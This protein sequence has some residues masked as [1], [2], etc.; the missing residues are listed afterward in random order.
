MLN[1][2]KH[3]EAKALASQF[4]AQHPESSVAW[5]AFGTCLL[6]KGELEEAVAAFDRALLLSKEDPEVFN[7]SAL[8]HYLLGKPTEAMRRYNEAIRLEPSYAEAFNNRGNLFARQ[9][10]FEFAFRDF[11]AA[12][13]I[14]ANYRDALF[15]KGVWLKEIGKFGE[16]VSYFDRALEVAPNDKKILWKKATAS[17][18]LGD[19]EAGWPLYELRQFQREG[20][21]F[22]RYDCEVWRGQPILGRT[23]LVSGEQGFGDAIQFVRYC[24]LLSKRG[25]RVLLE[26]Q[27]P[28]VRLF[29][30]LVG[31]D[32]VFALGYCRLAFDLHCMMM[33]LPMA[34]KTIASSIPSSDAYLR[35]EQDLVLH[36]NKRLA[37]LA[38]PRVGIV[39]QGGYRPNEPETL[40]VNEQRNVP[41]SLLAKFLD[42][43]E[44]VFV[45][46]QKGELAEQEI[47]CHG[48]RLWNKSK[49]V[50][51]TDELRDFADTAALICSLDLVVSVDTA[52]A[53]LAAA[54][55][56]PTW[57][58]NRFSTC[59][60]W[61]T[62]RED[63]PWYPTVKL[64]RQAIDRKW[65]PVLSR[66]ARDL[67][68]WKSNWARR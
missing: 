26:V 16:A 27:S 30:S 28:L 50:D 55:G 46:L 10:Q 58:L 34:F 15:S 24:T 43:L 59:W 31:V 65:E 21:D 1:A 48:D 52:T 8:T 53:H 42:P 33:S 23:I 61:L 64:Y 22:R 5:K 20:R 44:I 18:T 13:A 62:E 68:A 67:G 14:R 37:D 66:L 41:L 47:R 56:K 63:S 6:A 4:A 60:R 17:L 32:A 11:D 19:F 49:F 57:I 29:R 45:S 40:K 51:R 3:N 35:A 12:L 39:W 25:A 54:L 2:G 38:R 7:N 36:W 9:G